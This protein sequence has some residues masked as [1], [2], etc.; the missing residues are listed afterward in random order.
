MKSLNCLNDFAQF[1][2]KV[3]FYICAGQYGA[4]F[5]IISKPEITFYI[6]FA[7]YDLNHKV[8]KDE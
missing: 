5:L 3:T 2:P 4:I 1:C 7:K 8:Y 6:Y